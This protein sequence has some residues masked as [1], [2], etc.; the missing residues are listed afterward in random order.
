[1]PLTRLAPGRGPPCSSPPCLPV[2]AAHLVVCDSLPAV[3]APCSVRPE[4]ERLWDSLQGRCCSASACIASA[5][6]CATSFRQSSL[7]AARDLPTAIKTMSGCTLRALRS[8]SCKL[9]HHL[10]SPAAL[11]EQERWSARLVRILVGFLQRSSAFSLA[12]HQ[13]MSTATTLVPQRRVQRPC[14]STRHTAIATHAQ[15][16]P[17]E[18]ASTRRGLI[19]RRHVLAAVPPTCGCA[20]SAAARAEEAG[21]NAALDQMF[22][23][24][25]ATG[26]AH[27][28]LSQV[29]GTCRMGWCRL[30]AT[31]LARPLNSS[32]P[33]VLFPCF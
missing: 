18:T 26:E 14:A 7:A 16:P 10:L 24:A 3:A 28:V 9:R 4:P 20:V 1:M 22:A 8:C 27:Y 13:N 17:G 25:M 21:R 31:I 29:E 32:C 12:T 15:Q 11:R 30:P 6:S 33:C 19:T 2:L 5:G 23:A